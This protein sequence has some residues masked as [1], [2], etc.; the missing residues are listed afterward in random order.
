MSFY[1]LYDFSFNYYHLKK[2][3]KLNS[4]IKDDIL[5]QIDDQENEVY[6]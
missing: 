6:G 4:K 5:K 1:L 3:L 2:S